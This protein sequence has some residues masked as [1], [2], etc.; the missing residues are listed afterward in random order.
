MTS[1]S[2][3]AS[4]PPTQ[5]EQPPDK[6]NLFHEWTADGVAFELWVYKQD[7]VILAD[8]HWDFE[9]AGVVTICG[10]QMSVVWQGAITEH[11]Q[12]WLNA[13]RAIAARAYFEGPDE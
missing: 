8:P 9:K 11:P 6:M 13:Q 12:T 1:L 7:G 10:D 2:V 5:D 4:N 3:E